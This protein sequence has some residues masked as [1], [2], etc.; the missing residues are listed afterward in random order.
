MPFCSLAP[1]IGLLAILSFC[2]LQAEVA[3][4]HAEKMASGLKL[5]RSDIGQVLKQ[6]CVECHGGNKTRGGFD[7]TTRDG[8]L[9]GSADGIVVIPG[10][11]EASRLMKL[12]LHNEKPFMPAKHEKLPLDLIEKI[13][14]WI[15]AGAPY[16]KPLL[17]AKLNS[18]EMQVTHND[19]QYW[20]FSPIKKTIMPTINNTDWVQNEIDLFILAKLESAKIQPNLVAKNETI[21]RRVYFDLIGLP[22]TIDEID[23]FL[24]EADGN[25]RTALESVVDRL[26]NSPHYGERWG[27]HWLDL[28]RYADSFGFEQDTDR[29]HAFHYRDFVIKALNNDMPYDEFV[30]WQIAGD[31]IKPNNPLALMATGFLGA[32]V[33]PT[34][35]TEKEFESARYDELDDMVNTIGTA[36]LGMTIGCARCHDHKFDPIPMRD[37]YRMITTFA[38]TIRSE[39]DVDLSPLK[40]RDALSIWETKHEKLSDDLSNW[41]VDVLPKRFNHWIENRAVKSQTEFDWFLLDEIDVK[42]LKGAVVK[43][44]DDGS[45]LLKGD[46]PKDDQ[47][48]ISAATSKK[49]ITGI[50]I[51][52]LT[53]TSMKKRGPGRA[54]NGNFSLSDLRVFA[55]PLDGTSKKVAIKLVNPKATFEQNKE[56]LSVA[57]S[58]DDNKRTSGWAIDHGGIGKD[59]AAS[60]EFAS[61]VS[62][63]SGVKLTI[64]MD[65]FTNTKHTIGRPRFSITSQAKPI[66]LNGTSMKASV[67]NLLK[68]VEK[69]QDFSK[70]NAAKHAEL[71]AAYRL[72]DSEWIRLKGI[73]QSHLANKPKPKMT[74]IQVSSEGYKPI[75]HNADGRGFPHYYKEVH[76]LKRGD[77]NQKQEKMSQGFL[78]VLMRGKKNEQYWQELKPDWARTSFRRKALANWLVDTDHGAG[79]LLARVIVNRLWQHHFGRG[80]VST[81]S[82]FGLQGQLPTHPNLLDWLANELIRNGWR[83]KPL[84]KQILMSATYSQSSNYVESKSQVD[85]ENHLN[86]RRTPRRLEAEPIRD[87][88]LKISGLLDTT[89]FGKGTLNPSMERR[90]IYFQIKRSKLIPSMQLFDSPEPLVGQGVRP[91]TIISPQALL[92]MNNEQVR[93]AALALSRNFEQQSTESAIING[94]K[95]VIGRAPNQVEQKASAKFIEQQELAYLNSGRKNGLKLALIDFAQVLFGLNEFV[96]VY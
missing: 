10:E 94:Y 45:F 51:E 86:W 35:L 36:M 61:S 63:A 29:N 42:S 71:V 54:E 52:A 95:S 12:I 78:R 38:T 48:I 77:P 66:K 56:G 14:A 22:P 62:H 5:F 90:S 49:K 17:K 83:L 57:S 80:I 44:K 74:K 26:L 76:M 25:S 72:V 19:Q 9:K 64:E 67:A 4:D 21:L 24:L 55:E 20:A 92:F 70:L 73:I 15:D 30:R 93:K 8:M 39:I 3:T 96:Y 16:D 58:I 11:S 59:Q 33:F 28:A 40:T 88:F 13:A 43:F 69:I 91:S 6:H 47:W 50:R 41:E 84:H 2:Q 31:E 37:Y 34:Q 18:G 23:S 32:G 60:F 7:L 46:N 89:M 68:E 53:D 75:R 81:P 82:D 1:L 87:S 27:R 65:F 79:H 85:P